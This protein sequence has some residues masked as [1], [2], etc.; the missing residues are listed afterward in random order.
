MA[1]GNTWNHEHIALLGKALTT[2][3]D[4]GYEIARHL[5]DYVLVWGGGGG[6]DLAKSPHLAR[7]A[8]SVY[9]DHCPDDPTCRAFGFVDRQGTPSSM[10]KR[11]LLY[12][13]H[14]HQIKPDAIVPEDKFQEVYR[15]T[16]GKVRIY[17]VIG[18]SEESKQWVADPKNR[19]CDNPGSWF[20]PGQYPPGLKDILSRKTDFA[21]LEDFNRGRADNEYQEQYFRD[22]QDP[23]AARRKILEKEHQ[24]RKKEQKRSLSQ[25]EK[26][27]QLQKRDER[28]NSW[29]D[30]EDTT[31]M[32]QLINSN[33]I[34]GFKSLLEADPNMA[35]VRSKDGR[36]PMWWS[37]EKRNE[38]ITKLLMQV[39]VPHTDVDANGLT[40]MDLLDQ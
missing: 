29:S 6:D 33:D 30:T 13:L 23:E 18:I 4:S 24:E 5:A 38:E 20:C 35:F 7:I 11:S 8:N 12:G 40:P 19:K 16:Y 1:D 32:W 39:G 26:R 15:S 10:M 14:G 31:T 2:D 36:G 21:Q 37:F 22:L 25:D 17:Q 28:Y 27:I 34:A 3:L 9:R